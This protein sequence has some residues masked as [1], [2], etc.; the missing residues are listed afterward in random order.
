[1]NYLW[2]L[3]G[4]LG[5]FAPFPVTRCRSPFEGVQPARPVSLR[6]FPQQQQPRSSS[7][8]PYGV[9][10]PRSS[11]PQQPRGASLGASLVF[12]I[13]VTNMSVFLAERNARNGCPLHIGASRYIPT[14]PSAAFSRNFFIFIFFIFFILEHG[15]QSLILGHF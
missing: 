2:E 11:P 5:T 13:Y 7:P 1:M 9:Q 12:A 6:P 3:W 15:V 14:R 8:P 10:Q 4:I